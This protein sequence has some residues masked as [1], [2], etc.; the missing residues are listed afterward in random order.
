MSGAQVSSPTGALIYG[1][2][3]TGG[4][5]GL[6]SH[7]FLRHGEDWAQAAAPGSSLC[8]KVLASIHDP[9][10]DGRGARASLENAE[11][12]DLGNDPQTVEEEMLSTPDITLRR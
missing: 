4:C 12:K 2:P 11:G 9:L 3:N 10:S 5:R 8:A 1:S 6:G 7:L